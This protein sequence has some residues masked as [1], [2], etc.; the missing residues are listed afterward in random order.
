MAQTTKKITLEVFKPNLFKLIVAK[1]GD[2]DSRFIKATIVNDSKKVEISP[3]SIVTI[4]AKR[5]DGEA[6]SFQGVVN[7]N[8]TVTVPINYWMLELVGIL[9]CDV[10]IIGTDN[11][12]LTTSKFLIEVEKAA[13][14][15][16]NISTDDDCGILVQL[17]KDV[18]ELQDNT[19][20]E[21][22]SNM[23]I[24]QLLSNFSE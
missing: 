18:K 1:Q 17:I 22:I 11:S 13:C 6:K 4:N 19:N 9:E 16:E 5:G 8:G 14:T 3:S 20:V 15:D 12:R 24:E 2:N 23:E 7:D 10:S 21:A